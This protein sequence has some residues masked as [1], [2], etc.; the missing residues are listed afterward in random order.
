M[1]KNKV[2]RPQKRT[3][4]QIQKIVED[5]EQYIKENE[6]PTIVWFTANYPAIYSKTEDK[7][8]YINKEYIRDHKEF[9]QLRKKAIEKQEQYLLNWATK[10]K[11]NAS[12][13]IFR[14]KQPQHWYTDKTETDLRVEWKLEWI[15][16]T[17]DQ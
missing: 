3:P 4:E 7:K 1:A 12:V 9:S 10:N 2:G 14:L 13:S 16:V 15:K 8:S 17:L 6:D 5:F 11:L